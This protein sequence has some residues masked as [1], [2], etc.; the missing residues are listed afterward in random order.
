MNS[1]L[2]GGSSGSHPGDRGHWPLVEVGSACSCEGRLPL[3]VGQVKRLSGVGQQWR[4]RMITPGAVIGDVDALLAPGVGLD[5]GA[6]ALDDRLGKETGGYFGPKPQ[7]RT[8]LSGVRGS[9]HHARRSGGRNP[10][11]WWGLRGSAR[12][13]RGVEI[14]TS[15]LRSSRCSIR[16]PPARIL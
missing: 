7:P 16:L 3:R 5:E 10:R 14:E 4:R 15:S 9:R 1:Y 6:I 12:P 13:A 8:S 2:P 11:R